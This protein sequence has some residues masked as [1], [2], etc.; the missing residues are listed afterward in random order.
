MIRRI[1]I[2]FAICIPFAQMVCA[3]PPNLVVRLDFLRSRPLPGIATSLK[4][5]VLNP[6]SSTVRIDNMMKLSHLTPAGTWV[7]GHDEGSIIETTELVEEGRFAFTNADDPALSIGSSKTAE[8]Y[9]LSYPF[10]DDP[11]NS[12]PGR[13]TMNAT[14]YVKGE[15]ITSPPSEITVAQ[16]SGVD[17]QVWAL[18]NQMAGGAWTRSAANLGVCRQVAEAVLSTYPSSRYM[19]FLFD[20][21]PSSTDA[22]RVERFQRAITAADDDLT[23][24]QTKLTL[25]NFRSL[26]AQDVLTGEYNLDVALTEARA[27]RPILEDLA[28][29]SAFP[30]IRKEAQD[31]LQKLP[32]DANMRGLLN[33]LKSR[34]VLA[35]SSLTPFIQCVEAGSAAEPF[36]VRFGYTNPNRGGKALDPGSSN[37]VGPLPAD[38]GQPRYFL[39]GTHRDVFS[40]TSTAASIS[41]TL[42]GTTVAATRS[43][44]PRCTASPDVLPVRPITDCIKLEG[45]L[46]KAVFAYSNP[47]P[48]AVRLPFGPTNQT[49]PAADPKDQP[50]VF[51]PGLNHAAFK[52]RFPSSAPLTWTLDGGSTTATI[53]STT[54][55]CPGLK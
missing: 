45:T 40:A 35:P 51:L 16:P 49:T 14:I 25:G 24:D 36:I 13:I 54:T 43:S 46:W 47:N 1:F 55:T 23:R 21:S 31:L 50:I 26:K 28:S 12:G 20:C 33:F 17:A 52:V 19:P 37:G 53:G 15:Q 41:W 5:T 9:F 22:E 6:T 11:A 38:R 7:E 3:A 18:M 30:P 29:N 2:L 4:V 39:P 8:F 42:D 34:L 27:A 48:F 44:T 10:R 32:S